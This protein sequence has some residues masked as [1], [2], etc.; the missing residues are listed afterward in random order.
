M[1]GFILPVTWQHLCGGAEPAPAY[2]LP[3][4]VWEVLRGFS[5]AGGAVSKLVWQEPV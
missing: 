4:G 2:R 3:P 5:G 1:R